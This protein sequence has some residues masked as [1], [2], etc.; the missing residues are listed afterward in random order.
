M[1]AS[2]GLILELGVER[3]AGHLRTLHAPVIAWAERSGARVV[4]PQGTHGSGILC[5]AP[6]NVGEAFRAL[7]AARVICS[8]REGAIRLSPH[9]YNTLGEMERVV[10][11]LEDSTQ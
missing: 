7:K 2:V 3:I 5:V 9:V 8:M 11:V 10:S 1:N 4:S 6:P